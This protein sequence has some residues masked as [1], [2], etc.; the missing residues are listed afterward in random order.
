MCSFRTFRPSSDGHCQQDSKMKKNNF[1]FFPGLKTSWRG[2]G[3]FELFL[4]MEPR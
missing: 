1:G 3:S 2:V 4:F